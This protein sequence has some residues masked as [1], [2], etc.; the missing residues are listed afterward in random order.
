MVREPT[1]KGPGMGAGR[2]RPRG[3]RDAETPPGLRVPRGRTGEDEGPAQASTPSTEGGRERSPGH[4]SR[5]SSP[6]E[7]VTRPR[8]RFKASQKQHFQVGA[9]REVGRDCPH[10]QKATGESLTGST[11]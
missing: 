7:A 11:F 4:P 2:R 8:A 10:G 6:S 3:E 1:R 5:E 9:M